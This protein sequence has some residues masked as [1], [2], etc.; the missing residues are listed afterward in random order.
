[1]QKQETK[2]LQNLHRRRIKKSRQA[3]SQDSTNSPENSWTRVGC[4]QHCPTEIKEQLCCC[5]ACCVTFTSE[6][7]RR[8]YSQKHAAA[9]RSHPVLIYI[10]SQIHNSCRTDYKFYS[11]T[12]VCTI[13]HRGCELWGRWGFSGFLSWI[14]DLR[15]HPGLWISSL[16]F[17]IEFSIRMWVICTCGWD[18][19]P[20]QESDQVSTS[21]IL[22]SAL[23]LARTFDVSHSQYSHSCINSLELHLNWFKGKC[24]NLTTAL[25]HWQKVTLDVAHHWT[26]KKAARIV[27]LEIEQNG[28]PRKRRIPVAITLFCI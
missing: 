19:F 23:L 22:L 13:H 8:R 25:S 11:F 17:H 27:L 20:T 28:R 6:V 3:P 7:G 14:S 2:I 10:E 21:Q 1:M 18:F 4:H 12:T 5:T 9:A 26:S 24:K 16:H 15:G